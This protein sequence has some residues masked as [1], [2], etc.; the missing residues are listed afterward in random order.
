MRRGTIILTTIVGTVAV[1]GAGALAWHLSEPWR[2]RRDF[3]NKCLA[4]KFGAPTCACT[5]SAHKELRPSYAALVKSIVHDDMTTFAT[6]ATILVGRKSLHAGT[7]IDPADITNMLRKTAEDRTVGKVLRETGKFLVRHKYKAVGAAIGGAT[8]MA[9]YRAAWVGIEVGEAAITV[10]RHCR[11]VTASI[12][13]TWETVKGAAGKTWDVTKDGTDA[14]WQGTK[15][16]AGK[17]WD[18]TKYVADK[19]WDGTK[20]VADKTWDGTKY[21]ADKTWDGTKGAAGWTWGKVKDAGRLVGL[22]QE[23]ER[24]TD[25]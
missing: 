18:G 25:K 5:Y 22:G 11:F 9:V 13:S 24:S 21:V 3:V 7:G 8:A 23:A 17:T 6:N 4:N 1:I 12:P 20:Y 19:T 10:E 14:T 2:E 16:V 15:T